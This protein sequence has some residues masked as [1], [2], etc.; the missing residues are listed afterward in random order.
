MD[1][2]VIP[3]YLMGVVWVLCK[4][5]LPPPCAQSHQLNFFISGINLGDTLFLINGGFP[6]AINMSGGCRYTKDNM[7]NTCNHKL[8][9]AQSY[10]HA[11]IHAY[12]HTQWLQPFFYN[13][14][15]H[16]DRI[17]SF[18]SRGH[19]LAWKINRRYIMCVSVLLSVL[20]CV[21]L[22]TCRMLFYYAR[23]PISV[24]QF[25]THHHQDQHAHTC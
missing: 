24:S 16:T 8:H 25:D 6:C 19:P 18:S 23:E 10:M 4:P 12:L 1:L 22:F 5:T 13:S 15:V 2:L 11:L 3:I 9:C 21:F 14:P 17:K 20:F 7:S